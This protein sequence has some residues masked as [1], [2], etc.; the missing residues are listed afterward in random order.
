VRYTAAMSTIYHITTA[1]AWAEAQAAGSYAAD[2]LAT[3]GFI[4]LSTREQLLWVAD[5]FYRG[6]PGLLLFAVDT[7]RLSAEL[8]YE[9]SEPGMHFPHLYGPLNLD[10]VVAA[11]P[12]LPNPDGTFDLPPG[13]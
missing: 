9:E 8:R 3:E 2:S 4:H 10:A 5:R 13:V 11:R 12:F 7:G 1:E 6:Q